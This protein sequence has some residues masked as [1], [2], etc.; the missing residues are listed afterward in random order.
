MPG[1]NLIFDT[2]SISNF[3]LSESLDLIRRKYKG[4]A[5]ITSEIY[6]EI[7]DGVNAGHEGLASI[8]LLLK[9]KSLKIVHLLENEHEA[10]RMHLQ[11]LGRG[12]SSAIAIALHRKKVLVSDDMAAR[13]IARQL[14]I[15]FTGTIGILKGSVKD[16]LISVQEADSILKKMIKS[17]FYSPVNSISQIE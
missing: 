8:G 11:Y 17:G 5:S 12:E 15:D 6:D 10:Y 3:A 9:S 14:K 2:V 4:R 13:N 1:R 7:L 16:K